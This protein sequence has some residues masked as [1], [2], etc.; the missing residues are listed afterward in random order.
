MTPIGFGNPFSLPQAPPPETLGSPRS[1][2]KWLIASFRRSRPAEPDLA[3]RQVRSAQAG[4]AG[5]VRLVGG[6][7]GRNRYRMA[8]RGFHLRR[9][10]GDQ[11]VGQGR[12]EAAIAGIVHVEAVGP[13]R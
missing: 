13:D 11:R 6:Q 12:G 9:P 8:G 1:Y 4:G 3:A 10:V 2:S 5:S 7:S